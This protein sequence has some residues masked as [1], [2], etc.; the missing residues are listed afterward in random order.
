MSWL[1]NFKI[2][3]KISLIVALMGLVTIGTAVFASQR[4]RMMENANTDIVTRVDKSSTMAARCA[5]CR[6]LHVIRVPIVGGNHR[7]RQR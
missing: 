1:N 2:V 6:D 7:G 5:P 4:M 3:F